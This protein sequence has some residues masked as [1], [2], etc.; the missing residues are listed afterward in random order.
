LQED[1][2]FRAA[3]IRSKLNLL[4]PS[5]LR[6]LRLKGSITQKQLADE[7]EMKQPRISAM[8]RPG[9][10]KFS[11]ETLIRM[12]AAHK[13]GLQVKFVPFSELLHWE[14]NYRQDEFVVPRLEQDEAF[15]N[16]QAGNEN[17]NQLAA[18]LRKGPQSERAGADS[19]TGTPG[20]GAQNQGL[21]GL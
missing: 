21:G 17:S 10:I 15:L 1:V 18:G 7:A 19:N 11:L 16:P 9:E 2:K 14:N 6:G 4:I 3:Y 20:M 13:V 12:A 8:E 5:Q